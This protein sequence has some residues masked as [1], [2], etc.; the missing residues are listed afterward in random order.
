M[1]WLPTIALADEVGVFGHLRSAP[2]TS[3]ELA[4]ALSLDHT[5]LLSILRVLLSLKL[6][7]REDER[8]ALSSMGRNFLLPASPFYWKGLNSCLNREQLNSLRHRLSS[9]GKTDISSEGHPTVI[10]VWATGEFSDAGAQMFSQTFDNLTI[11]VAKAL[12]EHRIFKSIKKLLDI[13][14]GTGIYLLELVRAHSELKGTLVDL[15]AMV[16]V[17]NDNIHRAGLDERIDTRAL[18]IFSQSWPKGH[19]AV[20]ISN[21]FH[22]WSLD[23]CLALARYSYDA[24]PVGG[25]ICIHETLVNDD[26]GGGSFAASLSLMMQL[27]GQGRQYTFDEIK[28]VLE[29]VGFRDISLDHISDSFSLICGTK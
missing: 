8:Y 23:T 18:D 28:N 22:D 11:P 27:C 29:K 12:A 3:L 2:K 13:G 20:L 25:V 21:V 9:K 4:D 5:S 14:G 15:P 7:Q 16:R 19:D 1:Y 10:D 24:L 17:A 6:L 26:D